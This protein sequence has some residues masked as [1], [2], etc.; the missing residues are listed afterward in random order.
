M[1]DKE[2]E[3]E[4]LK[5]ML[6]GVQTQVKTKEKEVVRLKNKILILEGQAIPRQMGAMS[7]PSS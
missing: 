1:S 2:S 5:E 6:K 7:H 4:V 3:V